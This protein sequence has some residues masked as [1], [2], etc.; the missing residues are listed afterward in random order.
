MKLRKKLAGKVFNLMSQLMM[1]LYLISY[2]EKKNILNILS[3]SYKKLQGLRY[4]EN[5]H[6]SAAYYASTEID[7]AMNGF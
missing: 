4:G 1:Q 6:Q 5:P 7:G 3:V 2:L